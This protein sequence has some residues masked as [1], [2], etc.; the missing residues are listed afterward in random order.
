MNRSCPDLICLCIS[1]FIHVP[2]VTTSMAILGS[3]MANKFSKITVKLQNII[4]KCGRQ[5]MLTVLPPLPQL[6]R[7]LVLQSRNGKPFNENHQLLANHLSPFYQAGSKT[8]SKSKAA[9]TCDLE[10]LGH[11]I[12]WT[13]RDCFCF[14]FFFFF[15][16]SSDWPFRLLLQIFA[17]LL[18]L[19]TITS[20][21][22]PTA[23]TTALP[24]SCDQQLE[25]LNSDFEKK[26]SQRRT[27]DL[28]DCDQA[29]TGNLTEPCLCLHDDTAIGHFPNRA[30]DSD[31]EN[32][33]EKT[34]CLGY[35]QLDRNILGRHMNMLARFVDQERLEHSNAEPESCGCAAKI[36]CFAHRNAFPPF[37]CQE[38]CA[39]QSELCKTMNAKVSVI[40]FQ[41][42]TDGRRQLKMVAKVYKQPVACIRTRWSTAHNAGKCWWEKP[43]WNTSLGAAQYG[44]SSQETS[45]FCLR[46][47]RITLSFLCRS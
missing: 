36:T 30:N 21:P 38:E 4:I 1:N 12:A 3:I 17:T 20:C 13:R 31:V 24:A 35:K 16:L 9:I 29:C 39:L 47:R 41:K 40:L 6:V 45:S 2:K 37:F 18:C 28:T 44:Q 8:E 34:S 10:I 15:F 25:N 23:A 46:T 14:F 7:R 43:N 26:D 19:K 32:L 27:F 11:V 22:R 33:T 42:T 5:L